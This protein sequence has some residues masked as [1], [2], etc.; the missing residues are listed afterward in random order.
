MQEIVL[1]P[2]GAE[3]LKLSVS[4]TTSLT[5]LLATGGLVAFA[6]AARLLGRG[7]D[8]YKLAAYGVMIGLIAFSAII[9]SAPLGSPLM[10]RIGTCLIGLGGGFFSVGMLAVAMARERN[11]ESGLALGA[12]GA[13]QATAAGLAIALGG[14][15]ADAVAELAHRGVLGVALSGPDTGYG[16]VYH[17]EIGLLFATLVAIGPLVRS[18]PESLPRNSTGFGLAV[19]PG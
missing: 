6:F 14:A 5:A 4:A 16:F 18:V 1:E 19:F 10:F 17:I 3:V 12:W 13:V 9:F 2:Y 7:S 8:P 15:L 11:G